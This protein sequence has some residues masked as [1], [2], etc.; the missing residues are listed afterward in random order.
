[1]DSQAI[2]KR[3]TAIGAELVA[4]QRQREEIDKRTTVLLREAHRL[5]RPHG[6]TSYDGEPEAS[7][8]LPGP[9]VEG[10]P[11]MRNGEPTARSRA[12][13]YLDKMNR[14]VTKFELA[15]AL[16]LNPTQAQYALIALKK[17]GLVVQPTR[18]AWVLTKRGKAVGGKVPALQPAITI[19]ADPSPGSPS[20][21]R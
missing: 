4:L 20:D 10:V 19:E 14:A 6:T 18:G 13:D 2:I 16:G 11:R 9:Q 12:V 5:T 3:I 17:Q 7:P 15:Q 1:M 8:E 21:T